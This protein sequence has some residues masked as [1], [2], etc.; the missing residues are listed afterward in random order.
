MG[1]PNAQDNVSLQ[2][3]WSVDL[4]ELPA[5]A[6]WEDAWEDVWEGSLE[7]PAEEV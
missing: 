4:S 6:V 2:L 1:S 7:L 3:E 5:E